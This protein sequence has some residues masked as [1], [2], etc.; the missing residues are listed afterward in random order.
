MSTPGLR[1]ELN[2]DPPLCPCGNEAEYPEDGELVRCLECE[3]VRLEE[4]EL[5]SYLER[6][7]I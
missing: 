6:D 4:L 5:Q 1:L 7:L 2:Q 3:T